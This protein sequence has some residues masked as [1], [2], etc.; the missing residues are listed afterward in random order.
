[1]QALFLLILLFLSGYLWVWDLG[2]HYFTQ[3]NALHLS[4]SWNILKTFRADGHPPLYY[5][6]L[7]GV[8]SVFGVD[9]PLVLRSVSL[10]SGFLA[11]LVVFFLGKNISKSKSV[12]F[13]TAFLLATSPLFIL[14][15][16]VVRQY[17]LLVLFLFLILLFFQKDQFKLSDFLKVSI[18][19][20]LAA[21]THY[22]YVMFLPPVLV[23]GLKKANF[24]SSYSKR[25]YIKVF[26]TASVFSV[27]TFSFLML[28]SFGWSPSKKMSSYGG[29]IENLG[30]K[31]DRNFLEI[32]PTLWELVRNIFGRNEIW[33]ILILIFIGTV[34][35]VKDRKKD[36]L[37]MFWG[38]ILTGTCLSLIHRYPLTTGRHSIYL[39]PVFFI[40]LIWALKW[41]SEKKRWA[42]SAVFLLILVTQ[43]FEKTIRY[44][45]QKSRS[46]VLWELGPRFSEVSQLSEEL[47]RDSIENIIF[48]WDL[49]LSW[50]MESLLNPSWAILVELKKPIKRCDFIGGG[51]IN[52][53]CKCLRR[54]GMNK[55]V[56][57]L[58]SNIT[59]TAFNRINETSPC[60][61]LLKKFPISPNYVLFSLKL[62]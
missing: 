6:L 40:P 13:V 60:S 45:I 39:I 20:F 1:V 62:E 16:Q 51:N 56:N 27:A 36:L 4:V 14:Q 17:S 43:F 41:I 25:R 34:L 55:V 53:W 5:I 48:D 24:A 2:T 18:I 19:L 38:P 42:L 49:G 31:V 22:S 59:D 35:L 23:L 58:I 29:H 12:G 61:L 26:W 30:K 46:Q 7:K 21:C 11:V 32:G 33:V 47:S 44:D 57:F 10:V 9:S 28:S 37:I 52:N 50:Q 15:S 8:M 3:D 54:E